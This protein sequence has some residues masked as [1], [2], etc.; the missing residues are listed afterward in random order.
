VSTIAVTPAEN[1]VPEAEGRSAASRRAL[2][3]DAFERCILRAG[4]HRTTMQDVAKEAAMS[5]GNLYRYFVSKEA[6]V[7]GLAERDRERFSADFHKVATSTDVM[8]AFLGLGRKHFVEEPRERCIQFMEIWAES[9]RNPAVAAVCRAMDREVNELL[10]KIIDA[11]KAA[12]QVPPHVDSAAMINMLSIFADGVFSHRALDPD[13]DAEE[14]FRLLQ[15][16][17]DAILTGRLDLNKAAP[18][19]TPATWTDEVATKTTL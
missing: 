16:I 1:A 10:I 15:T 2:I 9:T 3:L 7:S 14:G 11:A 18:A 13:F 17:I 12:G 19:P 8:G 5:A 4:F 6:L